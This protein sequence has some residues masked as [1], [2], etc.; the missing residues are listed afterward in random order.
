VDVLGESQGNMEPNN[1]YG[2]DEKSYL[3]PLK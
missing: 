3:F 1:V 2:Y